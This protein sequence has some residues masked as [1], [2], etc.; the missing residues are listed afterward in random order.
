MKSWLQ[1]KDIEMY[2]THR[3]GKSV[4]GEKFMKTLKNKIYK[5]ITSVSKIV[6]IDKLDDIVPKCN[7]ACT[8]Q[9]K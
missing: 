6:Y 1:D 4:F 8:A 2:S 5:C 9:S 3:E 7:N